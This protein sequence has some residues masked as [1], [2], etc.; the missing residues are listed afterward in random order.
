MVKQQLEQQYASVQLQPLVTKFGTTAVRTRGNLCAVLQPSTILT[1]PLLSP[2]LSFAFLSLPNLATPFLLPFFH[3]LLTPS[4]FSFPLLPF[5]HI[6]SSFL[7]SHSPILSLPSLSPL[8]FP[9]LPSAAKIHCRRECSPDQGEAV[10]W[11]DPLW[12]GDAQ[13][14]VIPEGCT[15]DWSS[16]DQ[17]SHEHRR[18]SGVSPHLECRPVCVLYPAASR[19]AH[20]RVSA[21]EGRGR[22]LQ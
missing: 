14:Q 11:T 9:S 1:P 17:W 7:S 2:H 20:C 12:D 22:G 19:T 10:H 15:L 5:P 18:M 3:L 16:A 4:L 21:G 8:S 13:D 6:Y